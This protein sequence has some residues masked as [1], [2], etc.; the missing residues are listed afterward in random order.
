MQTIINQLNEVLT[1]MDAEV[2]ASSQDWARGRVA[3]LAEF[4]ASEEYK[5]LRG[6]AWA[7][8][9]KLHEIAGG[10]TWYAV[11]TQNS[12]AAI[13]DFISK[14]CA[15][16]VAKRNSMISKKLTAAEVNEVT[17]TTFTTTSDGFNGVFRVN[18]NKGSKRV[19][20]RTIRAGGYNIQC[21]HLRI[22]VSVK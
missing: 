6:N 22:L 14:N 7:L 15:A 21:L 4:K 20:V 18:T 2:L 5:T 13:E 1:P 10:K 17:E 16:V 19:E 12:A 8:Y 11:F 9:P 3:A